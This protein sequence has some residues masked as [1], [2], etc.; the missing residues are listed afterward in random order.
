MPTVR[1]PTEDVPQA[2]NLDL[3]IRVVEAIGS[4]A[5][6]DGDIALALGG[7]DARQGRYYRRAAEVLGLIRNIPHQNRSVLTA[8]GTAFLRSHGQQ[9]EALLAQSV[10]SSRIFQR[11]LPFLEARGKLGASRQELE[12]FVQTA[13]VATTASMVGRRTSTIIAWLTRTG[14][15]QENRERYVLPSLP[16]GVEI[17][18]YDSVEEPLLPK[19]FEMRDY[20]AVA[21]RARNVV[22]S[23]S[24]LV[25]AVARERANDAHQMLINLVASRIR[26]AG[27]IP[28]TNRLIDLAA[29]LSNQDYLFEMKSTTASNFHSQ[30]RAAISQLYEYRYTEVLPSAKLVVVVEH[31]PGGEVAW[32][33]DYVVNDRKLLIAWDGD[34]RTLHYPDS[35]R[36]DLAFL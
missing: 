8:P 11:I 14:I 22:G 23:S 28:K 30:V 25:D 17:V 27:G 29:K 19:S 20:E 2:D 10:V 26:T 6:T 21:R 15:L 1:L 32:M 9:R 12:G 7:Y 3:V 31:P 24:V 35:L 36:A 13:T 34:K 4:G 5:T 16:E 18:T 33:V